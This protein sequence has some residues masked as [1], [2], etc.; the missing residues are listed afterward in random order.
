VSDQDQVYV[1]LQG[2][3]LNPDR[4]RRFTKLRFKSAQVGFGP[5]VEEKLH[6]ELDAGLGGD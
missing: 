2:V 1:I 6:Q 5:A 4:I 3:Q